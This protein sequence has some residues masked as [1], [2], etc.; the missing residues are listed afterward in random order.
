MFGLRQKLLLGFGG[1][2]MILLIVSGLGIAVLSRYRG[3]LD[4]FYY[5][6]WRSVEFGQNMTD[7]LQ[8]LNDTADSVS[9]ANGEPTP[10]ALASARFAAQPW[11]KVF[12]DNCTAEDNNITLNGE[13]EIAEALTLAWSG[14]DLGGQKQTAD[15]YRDE[16]TTLLSD[17]THG[18]A[19]GLLEPGKIGNRGDMVVVDPVAQPHD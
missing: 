12:D 19:R 13:R 6:N 17:Q 4:Q 2:L 16:Y 8:H 14:K 7:A 1:L 10:A 3:A 11:I 18:P 5:E 9:G 15:N